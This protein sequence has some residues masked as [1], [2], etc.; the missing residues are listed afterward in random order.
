MDKN[1]SLAAYT[2]LGHDRDRDNTAARSRYMF[3]NL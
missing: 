2:P 3:Q 1:V